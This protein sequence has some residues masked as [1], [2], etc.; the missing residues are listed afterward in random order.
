M[1]KQENFKDLF[2]LYIEKYNKNKV[3]KKSQI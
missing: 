2:Y 3:F 1:E